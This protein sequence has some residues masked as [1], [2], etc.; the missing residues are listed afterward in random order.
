MRSSCMQQYTSLRPK[1]AFLGGEQKSS[2]GPYDEF[3][4]NP[5]SARDREGTGGR[6]EARPAPMGASLWVS[7]T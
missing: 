5:T 3:M 4:N 7:L 2:F 1:L 6:G